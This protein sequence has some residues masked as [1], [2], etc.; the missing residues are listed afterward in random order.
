VGPSQSHAPVIRVYKNFDAWFGE[1]RDHATLEFIGKDLEIA[2]D[3][4]VHPI[5]D[6]SN[7]GIPDKTSVV[8]ITSASAPFPDGFD[9]VTQQNDPVAQENLDDFVRAGGVLI[10]DLANNLGVVT[11]SP[12]YLAPGAM[13]QSLNILPSIF[14][15]MS[16]MRPWPLRRWAPMGCWGPKTTTRLS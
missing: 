7:F 3:Y 5:S 14:P 11:G 10:L 6:L 12:G 16:K 1:N 9:A 8:L 15:P 13:A 4:F 2:D